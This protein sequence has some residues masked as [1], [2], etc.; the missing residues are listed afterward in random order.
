MVRCAR[1]AHSWRAEVE[2]GRPVLVHEQPKAED[3]V[4]LPQP[5]QPAAGT[6]P[7]FGNP[8]LSGMRAPA[9]PK[10][11]RRVSGVLVGWIGLVAGLAALAS[12]TIT[13]RQPIIAA[14]APA[15]RLYDWVGLGPKDLVGLEIRALTASRS[16]DS[17]GNPI[18]VISGEVANI[19]DRPRP[20]PHAIVILLDA[21]KQPLK[22]WDVTVGRDQ[23][24][25]GEVVK[26]DTSLAAPPVT[27]TSAEVRFPPA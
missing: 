16:S 11:K 7:L 2:T 27:A 21:Q 19:T 9:L 5:V 25:P 22:S 23:L 14:W 24:L 12:S 18:L 20:V 1:C 10:A 26:L 17:D 3:V 8:D 15:A 6:V 13:F 4:S